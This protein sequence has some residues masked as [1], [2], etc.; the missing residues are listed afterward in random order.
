MFCPNFVSKK[1]RKKTIA[2]IPNFDA[3]IS[4]LILKTEYKKKNGTI[5]IIA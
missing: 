5:S 2:K 1:A 4:P 3:F